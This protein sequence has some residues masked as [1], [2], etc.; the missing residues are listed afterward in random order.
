MNDREKAE[1]LA[2]DKN[3]SHR[4]VRMIDKEGNDFFVSDQILKDLRIEHMAPEN[5]GMPAPRYAEDEG[6]RHM[7]SKETQTELNELRAQVEKLM[8]KKPA[9]APAYR[10]ESFD[11]AALP[12]YHMDFRDGATATCRDPDYKEADFDPELG[13]YVD[14][15]ARTVTGYG[16]RRVVL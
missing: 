11:P 12:E 10:R 5:R 3:E 15:H 2:A 4:R 13:I 6:E 9:K 7:V 8:G 16:G 14:K 1:L